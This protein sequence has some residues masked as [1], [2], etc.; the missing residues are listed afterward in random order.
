MPASALPTALTRL[1]TLLKARPELT[2]VGV[3]YGEPNTEHNHHDNLT[4]TGGTTSQDWHGLGN[5]NRRETLDLRIRIDVYRAGTDP[6]IPSERAWALTETLQAVI[7][8]DDTLT[9]TVNWLRIDRVDQ[10]AE[11]F[12]DGIRHTLEV[13]LTATVGR[14]T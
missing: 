13:T 8:A 1:H 6:H 11:P 9:G 7:D 3:W 12:T 4:I 5:Q 10:T 14:L 2:G